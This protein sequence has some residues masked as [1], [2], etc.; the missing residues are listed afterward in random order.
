[1]SGSTLTPSSSPFQ[2]EGDR[3]SAFPLGKG[4]GGKVATMND[5]APFPSVS[6]QASVGRVLE[7][8]ISGFRCSCH[9]LDSAPPLGAL[10]AVMDG[11]PTI[12]GVVAEVR[13]QPLDAGR[14][15]APR[16]GP[17]DDRAAVL[18]QNPQ[19]PA[20]LHTTFDAVVVGYADARASVRRHLPDGPAPMYARVRTCD[21]AETA[22]VFE[23][24]DFLG[25][26]LA[27]GPLA[28]E[29]TAACLRRAAGQQADPRAFLIR[30]GR[31]LA[32]ELATEPER[33]TAILSRVR[34]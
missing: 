32:Q 10:V 29:V 18:A 27:A 2:G 16:G 7:A 6:F 23:R 22:R 31:A 19:I 4:A 17:G 28:D 25:L 12:Y 1:M 20:L 30:A 5:R 24:F 3:S 21:A 26:L 8:K 14:Q 15:L 34:P 13:T 33:L 11:G 9:E